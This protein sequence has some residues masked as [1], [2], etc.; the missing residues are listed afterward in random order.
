MI[1]KS[2]AMVL[3]SMVANE[4]ARRF[5]SESIS[6]EVKKSEGSRLSSIKMETLEGGIIQTPSRRGIFGKSGTNTTDAV[7]I[8]V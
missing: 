7:S 1:E 3:R 5:Y 4:I 2:T 8:K 6:V